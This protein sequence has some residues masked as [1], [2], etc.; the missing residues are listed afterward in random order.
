MPVAHRVFPELGLAVASYRGV[1]T[2]AE[3]VAAYDR[4]F[5]EG[6][7]R[8]GFVELCD[9]RQVTSFDIDVAAM[10]TVSAETARFHGEAGRT[11]RSAHLIP[12]QINQPMSRL[13]EAVALLDRVETCRLFE[14]VGTALRWLGL[15]DE[16]S[17]Q[18]IERTGLDRD[19]ARA[20]PAAR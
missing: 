2:G 15:S 9:S 13:Y 11:T 14:D 5:R 17:A 8:P 18:I 6:L 12:Q 16:A 20:S 10:M 19:P 4:L 1:V 7:Y 3:F